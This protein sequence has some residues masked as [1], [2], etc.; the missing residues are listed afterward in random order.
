MHK[1]KNEAY[2]Y[3]FYRFFSIRKGVEL[4]LATLA[5]AVDFIC[6]WGH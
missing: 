6:S 4:S 2:P 3:N 5:E 1:G